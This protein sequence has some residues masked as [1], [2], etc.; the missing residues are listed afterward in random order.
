MVSAQV[1]FVAE[2]VGV[3]VVAEK[4]NAAALAAADVVHARVLSLSE[5]LEVSRC[6]IRLPPKTSTATAAVSAAA[7]DVTRFCTNA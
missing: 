7:S 1:A 3:T 6:S 4:L 2:T 5:A